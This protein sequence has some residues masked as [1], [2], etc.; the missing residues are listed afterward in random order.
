MISWISYT[1]ATVSADFQ[2][3][4]SFSF[5][6]ETTETFSALRYRDHTMRTETGSGDLYSSQ[7]GRTQKVSRSNVFAH[8]L[9]SDTLET[10]ISKGSEYTSKNSVFRFGQTTRPE[11]VYAYSTSYTLPKETVS[12][13]TTTTSARVN[14]DLPG[15][16]TTTIVEQYSYVWDTVIENETLTTIR[17]TVKLVNSTAATQENTAGITETFQ[18]LLT[19]LEFIT[20]NGSSENQIVVGHTIWMDSSGFAFFTRAQA[21]TTI[22]FEAL[23][24]Y[25]SDNLDWGAISEASWQTATCTT[26][27][28]SPHYVAL[29]AVSVDAGGLANAPEITQYD[30]LAESWVGD[31][32]YLS[33]AQTFNTIIEEDYRKVFPFTTNPIGSDEN[34]EQRIG[35]V[36]QANSLISVL[37]S[38]K[39]GVHSW[40]YNI[41]STH[42]F[43]T[44]EGLVEWPGV[45]SKS[46][47]GR[48]D[49]LINYISRKETR[50]SMISGTNYIRSKPV[51]N[52]F[53]VPHAHICFATLN[54]EGFGPPDL[55]FAQSTYLSYPGFLT[56]DNA[57]ITLNDLSNFKPPSVYGGLDAILALPSF[58]A[59]AKPSW[60]AVDEEGYSYSGYASEQ[61]DWT[62]ATVDRVGASFSSSWVWNI[63]SSSTSSSS[64]SAKLSTDHSIPVAHYWENLG[65]GRVLGGAQYPHATMTIKKMPGIYLMTTYD[66]STSGT[67]SSIEKCFSVVTTEE[68][69][70][71]TSLTIFNGLAF[72]TGYGL[73]T[74]L[75]WDIEPYLG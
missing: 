16:R 73:E 58:T 46:Y 9:L 50:Q 72:I 67:S 29:I 54:R 34:G 69:V 2:G 65:F 36:Y 19:T 51:L 74:H 39:V 70:G 43:T 15:R 66:H 14:R 18:T 5:Q 75:V 37:T 22:A 26:E 57:K 30:L 52:S 12:Q 4:D 48:S 7:Y 3:T 27:F 40:G 41:A 56:L 68:S 28:F 59:Y 35:A 21:N 25:D 45:S 24:P 49:L 71:N 64:G 23:S 42:T 31:T 53:R 17:P 33:I 44:T 63:N 47:V 60:S 62:T 55:D 61:S 13:Y 20:W 38:T 32:Y 1:T 10:R 11:G 8:T 6:K